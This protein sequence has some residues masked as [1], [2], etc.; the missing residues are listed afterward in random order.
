MVETTG[1]GSLLPAIA[2]LLVLAVSCSHPAP[3]PEYV[4]EIE[5][6]RA[7]RLER[8]RADDGW[9]TLVALYWLEPGRHP[10]GSA[11][12]NDLVLPEG[13]APEHA[14]VLVREGDEVTVEAL[15]GAV[16][17]VDGEP[18]RGQRLVSDAEGRPS[19]V[20][21]G[22][23]TFYLIRR[24]ERLAIRAKDPESP[25]RT[26]FAGL[27]HFPIDPSYRVTGSFEPYAE[28][29]TVE[30]P[31]V[32]GTKEVMLVPGVV[33]FSL[34]G[35]DLTLEPVLESPDA[36]SFFFVF[37]DATSGRETYEACR[38]LDTERVDSGPV[39]LDFNRAYNPPCAFTPYATCPLPPPGNVLPVRIEAGEKRY[40][41]S[42]HHG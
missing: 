22:R 7:E 39:V 14:G 10:F 15:P 36:D 6:W 40:A 2:A 25:V 24:G 28:P 21:T 35:R 23:I 12:D 19:L 33:R 42:P 34:R 11:E 31:T 26:R 5:R 3:D 38:F 16:V 41:H 13:S 30:V 17:L 8:L 20:R 1:G 4:Q 32:A 9:L 27:D 29:R 37:R 18:A